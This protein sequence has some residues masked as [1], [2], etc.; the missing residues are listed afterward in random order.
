MTCGY[1]RYLQEP[2]IRYVS[3]LEYFMEELHTRGVWVPVDNWV[4]EFTRI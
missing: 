3:A 1:N 4:G 2:T